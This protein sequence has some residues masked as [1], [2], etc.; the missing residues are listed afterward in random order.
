MTMSDYEPEDEP[1]VS[2]DADSFDVPAIVRDPAAEHG[3]GEQWVLAE[4][5]TFGLVFAWCS[6]LGTLLIVLFLA[7]VGGIFAVLLVTPLLLGAL[8][9]MIVGLIIGTVLC[10]RAL[11]GPP[12]SWPRRP[13]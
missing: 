6:L 11:L 8:G 9:A 2:E 3:P 5:P 7:V 1:G 10:S 4:L 12:S 13:K